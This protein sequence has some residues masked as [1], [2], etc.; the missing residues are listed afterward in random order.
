MMAHT[1]GG[2]VGFPP[3]PYSLPGDLQAKFL[4]HFPPISVRRPGAGW[5][6]R[7]CR[8]ESL[9]LVTAVFCGFRVFYVVY[10]SHT[11]LGNVK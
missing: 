1:M 6:L 7:A 5:C 9:V 10:A 11:V 3:L 4:R 8:T 2:V